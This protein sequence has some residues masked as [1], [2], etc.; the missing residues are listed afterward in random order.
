MKSLHNSS[1][2]LLFCF[3]LFCAACHSNNPTLEE[4]ITENLI[5]SNELIKDQTDRL[6]AS[7]KLADEDPR[8]HE[9]IEIWMSRVAA[10]HK[11]SEEFYNYIDNMMAR[12]EI[13][14]RQSLDTVLAK[15]EHYRR[16][17]PD[18]LLKDSFPSPNIH[19]DFEKDV[20]KVDVEFPFATTARMA[21]VSTTASPAV[22]NKIKNDILLSEYYLIEYLYKRVSVDGD[23]YTIFRPL[24][25]LNY[26]QLKIGQRLVIT[27]GIGAY[28]TVA[29]KVTIDGHEFKLNA[30]GYTQYSLIAKGSLG[31]HTIPV[32]IE[33]A[34][35]DGAPQYYTQNIEYEIAP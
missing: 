9:K 6:L 12:P 3:F 2:S 26:S 31:K 35:P 15:V 10:I 25:H 33:Y 21:G 29:K 20:K 30:E 8:T 17:I 32:K 13:Q 22:C 16:T 23:F 4:E 11:M 28:S 5:K 18:I 14:T 27:A 24:I 19:K 34:F 1:R 7:I